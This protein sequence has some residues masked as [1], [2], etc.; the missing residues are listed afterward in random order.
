[1]IYHPGIYL[2]IYIYIHFVQDGKQ[3]PDIKIPLHNRMEHNVDGFS[4]LGFF[5]DT[6]AQRGYVDG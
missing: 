2:Y 1:M 4:P 6:S 5:A 3:I